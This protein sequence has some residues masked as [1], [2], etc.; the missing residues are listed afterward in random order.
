M[1]VD[2][3]A[4]GAS[5]T[6]GHEPPLSIPEAAVFLNV[7]DRWVRRAVRERRLPYLKVGRHV[8]FL[9]ED[10]EA[11]LADSRVEPAPAPGAVPEPYLRRL[12]A[13][14]PRRPAGPRS[15]TGGDTRPASA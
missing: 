9:V 5:V 3:T 2:E 13:S 7:T 1:A 15:G 8:R 10:L 14:V 12:P 6:P 11:F 4:R